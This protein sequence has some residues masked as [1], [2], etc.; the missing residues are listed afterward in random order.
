MSEHKRG[1]L[2]TSDMEFI[3]AN[4]ETMDPVVIAAVSAA[5]RPAVKVK[6]WG[7]GVCKPGGSLG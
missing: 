5:L 2:S 4:V 3:R 1:A 7:M 6:V